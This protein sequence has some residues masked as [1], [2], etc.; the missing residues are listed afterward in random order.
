[1]TRRTRILGFMSQPVHADSEPPALHA[2]AMENLRYIRRTMEHASS[3][4]AVP[5]KGQVAMGA[6]AVVAAL[7]ASRQPDGD[8]WLAVWLIEAL[9]G[10]ALGVSFMAIKAR[11]AGQPLLSGPGGRFLFSFTLPVLAAAALSVPLARAGLH[12]ALPGLWLL[13]YGVAIAVGGVVSIPIVP[14]LGACFMALGV[15][16]L[17]VRIAPDMLMALGFGALHIGFGIVIARRHGG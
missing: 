1:M 15:A 8:H 11:G 17:F 12:A 5:G 3:F 9:I 2:Q 13:L 4:T 16:G 14:V 7:I 6:S 10:V